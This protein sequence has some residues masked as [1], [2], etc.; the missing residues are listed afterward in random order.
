MD[1]MHIKIR[2]LQ[3]GRSPEDPIAHMHTEVKLGKSNVAPVEF[4]TNR[5]LGFFSMELG[6]IPVLTRPQLQKLFEEYR[7]YRGGVWYRKGIRHA[8]ILRRGATPKEFPW[9]KST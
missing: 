3:G 5:P 4:F 1:I 8:E 6:D 7:A 2:F 9:P